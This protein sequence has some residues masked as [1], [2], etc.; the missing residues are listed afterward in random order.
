MKCQILIY[1]ISRDLNWCIMTLT[2]QLQKK[3]L[4]NF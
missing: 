2:H 1:L 4:L 3:R